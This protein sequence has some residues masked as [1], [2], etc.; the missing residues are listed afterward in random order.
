MFSLGAA[1]TFVEDWAKAASRSA[2]VVGVTRVRALPA[3]EDQ[4]DSS[5]A[6]GQVAGC[7]V[8][9]IKTPLPIR[10]KR[11]A[12][13][14]NNRLEV[15][16]TIPAVRFLEREFGPIDIIHSHFYAGSGAVPDLAKRMGIPFVHTEHSSRLVANPSFASSSR[17]AMQELF[18][19]AACVMFVGADQMEFVRALGIEG[20]FQVV[21]NP[22]D[23]SHFWVGTNNYPEEVRLITV[24]N[25]IP[26]KRHALILEAVAEA[27]AKDPR[28]RL[29]IVGSGESQTGLKALSE[30]LG[31]ASV[32]HFRGRVERSRVAELLAGSN[33]YVHASAIE[34]FGVAIVEALFAGLPVVVARAGGVTESIPAS[35]GIVVDT[36]ESGQFASAILELTRRIP[37]LPREAIATGSRSLFSTQAVADRLGQIY[38]D[39]IG[40]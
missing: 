22:V 23:D 3:G 29:D 12:R 38:R 37:V 17:R 14:L 36:P 1:G 35:M 25:L 24:G 16:R 26:L 20:P 21:P 5:M 31:I 2:E 40:R 19:A 15:A 33:V 13:E 11:L 27:R 32:V 4:I 7:P 30:Q 9:F 10:P 8:V 39:A 18:G 28:I 6:L 34:T